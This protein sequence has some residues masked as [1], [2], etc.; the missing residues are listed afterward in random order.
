[1]KLPRTRKEGEE[2]GKGRDHK[3]GQKITRAVA[4]AAV[5]RDERTNT[6][7]KNVDRVANPLIDC[8]AKFGAGRCQNK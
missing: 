2:G 6:R 8:N 5:A 3:N 7:E 4:M 1:M